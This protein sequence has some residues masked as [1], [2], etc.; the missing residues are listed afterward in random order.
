M[1]FATHTEL[2]I[3]IKQIIMLYSLSHFLLDWYM[4]HNAHQSCLLYVLKQNEEC[5]GQE[6]ILVALKMGRDLNVPE[7]HTWRGQYQS[8]HRYLNCTTPSTT[9]YFHAIKRQQLW[10]TTII[11]LHV[12]LSSYNVAT[13]Y[14]YM[15]NTDIN[16]CKWPKH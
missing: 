13:N 2:M 8:L 12:I 15:Y 6:L 3:K 7:I 10:L 11:K 16:I 14:M 1:W 4:Q 5:S 9:M